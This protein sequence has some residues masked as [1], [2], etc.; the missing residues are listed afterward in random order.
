MVYVLNS[1]FGIEKHMFLEVFI[2]LM[3][4]IP[5]SEHDQWV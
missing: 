1:N 3:R 4:P 2:A 5:S